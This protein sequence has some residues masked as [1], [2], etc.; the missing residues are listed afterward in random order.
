MF[1]PA[2]RI[3]LWGEPMINSERRWSPILISTRGWQKPLSI[4]GG[5]STW[6]AA[7]RSFHTSQPV[8]GRFVA[9]TRQGC[10][11]KG[12]H[13]F[14]TTHLGD[15]HSFLSLSN[16]SLPVK[17]RDLN[18]P[19]SALHHLSTAN[20]VGRCTLLVCVDSSIVTSSSKCTSVEAFTSLFS[21][22]AKSRAAPVSN[23]KIGL[24]L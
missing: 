15:K 19:S 1:Y 4:G 11:Y 24:L 3:L 20:N 17:G 7:E 12:V 21:S 22:C 23:Q 8:G 5:G 16:G 6:R 2:N 14:V 13:I 10:L 9:P 18:I